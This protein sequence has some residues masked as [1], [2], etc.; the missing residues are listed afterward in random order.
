MREIITWSLLAG[1]VLTGCA[2]YTK[3]VPPPA[4]AEVR[5]GAPCPGARWVEGHWTWEG[6][7]SGYR[8]VPGHWR[9]P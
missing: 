1:L 7:K 8:W 3:P 6:K 5:Q 2:I 4:R 9:C